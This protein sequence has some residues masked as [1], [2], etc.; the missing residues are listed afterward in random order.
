MLLLAFCCHQTRL[1]LDDDDVKALD[2]SDKL[3]VSEAFRGAG[4][5]RELEEDIGE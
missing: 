4:R 1:T 5:G 2:E 3:E